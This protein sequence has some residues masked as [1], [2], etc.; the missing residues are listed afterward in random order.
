M[1]KSN[2]DQDLLTL[3]KRES[4][5]EDSEFTC[6]T[7]DQ[8]SH[9]MPIEGTRAILLVKETIEQRVRKSEILK[10]IGNTQNIES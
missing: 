7:Y 5:S 3:F 6:E 2:E 4:M 8:N 10:D 1:Y 9:K